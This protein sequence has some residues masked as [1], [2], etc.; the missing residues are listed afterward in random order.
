[1]HATHKI[2]SLDGSRLPGV[3]EEDFR[4]Y[5]LRGDS[6]A[7][8]SRLYARRLGMLGRGLRVPPREAPRI[9]A[10]RCETEAT[11]PEDR[12]RKVRKRS[13][14][15]AARVSALPGRVPGVL[16]L[17][18]AELLDWDDPP[19]FRHFLRVDASEATVDIRC[20]AVTGCAGLEESPPLED[21]LRCTLQAK[22]RWEW[23]SD[24]DSTAE[25][26]PR[27]GPSAS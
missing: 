27:G 11:R 5:P 12:D 24:P 20:Y 6:L 8:F 3:R 10:D 22:G 18:F 13:R 7:R 14:K 1:M 17:P 4:C 2:P 9:M 21:H 26:A 15:A 16:H 23:T 25:A 19:L